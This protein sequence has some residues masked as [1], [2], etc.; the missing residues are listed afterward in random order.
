MCSVPLHQS[1]LNRAAVLAF[2]PFAICFRKA[3]DMGE[4]ETL[5]L[6]AGE[7]SHGAW[8]SFAE[9]FC[10]RINHCSLHP[11]FLLRGT[12][13]LI[14]SIAMW[15]QRRQTIRNSDKPWPLWGRTCAYHAFPH[16]DSWR[17]HR[18]WLGKAAEVVQGGPR[19][20]ITLPWNRSFRTAWNS[21]DT[22]LLLLCVIKYPLTHHDD[23]M[24]EQSPKCLVLSNLAQ[25][26]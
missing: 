5:I 6:S 14:G 4:E 9:V 17:Y 23:R 2:S 11:C 24:D 10:F 20:P 21:P 16:S 18:G 8:R 26:L 15:M 22:V 25:V 12:C 13:W 7:V 19:T 3:K 1:N